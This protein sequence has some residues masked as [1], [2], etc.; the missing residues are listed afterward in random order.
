MRIG[1]DSRLYSPN[2]TGIGRYVYELIHNLLKIDRKNHYVL[3][4]NDP[5]YGKFDVRQKNV[6]KVRVN[7]P[8][9]SF[10]EQF[11]FWRILENAGLDL[12]HFTHFN[13]PA[14]YRKPSVVTIHDLTL[15]F[16]PGRKMTDLFHRAAYNFV[17][18]SIVKRA[19]KIIAVSN[20][21][22]KDIK[23]LFGIKGD[24][25][26][27]IYEGVNPLFRK[28]EASAAA[29][30]VLAKL[31][32]KK[33]CILY[34]GVWRSHKNL[35]NLIRAFGILKKEHGFAG[36][37]VITGKKD[38]W[39]SEVQKAAADENLKNDIRFTGLLSDDDL[40]SLYNEAALYVLPSLYEG[41]GLP[42]LE[43]FACGTPVCA[44]NSSCIPEICGQDAALLFDPRNPHDMAEKMAFVLNH[45]SKTA[46]LT[47]AGT[48]RLK[49]FSWEK[50]A[51][52][53]LAVYNSISSSKT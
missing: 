41:F 32:I 30:A 27:V 42:V 34:T 8:H 13:A 47:A 12:M 37:L 4:F 33:P 21:T 38:P 36:A 35:P 29:E 5:F 49:M 40:V 43:A 44:S 53:T 16:F 18:R 45:P 39:Y 26:K 51:A 11:E 46:E 52:E 23:N 24:K 20:N 14:L 15:S 25:I 22:K 10:K 2:F 9:Y 28:T 6:E 31:D 50:M 3:F 19:Q 48:T 7:A 17:I 1:I